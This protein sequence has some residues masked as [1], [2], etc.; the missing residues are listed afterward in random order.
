MLYH[1]TFYLSRLY[2]LVYIYIFFGKQVSSA[3]RAI[4]SPEFSMFLI[5]QYLDP[6]PFHH[7]YILFIPL[8]FF[9][10]TYYTSSLP[11]VSCSKVYTYSTHRNIRELLV[12]FDWIHIQTNRKAN[13]V[14]YIEREL[15][16]PFLLH[17]PLSQFYLSFF[18]LFP[19][20]YSSSISFNFQSTRLRSCLQNSTSVRSI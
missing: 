4:E 9:I 6:S 13:L 15:F 20:L 5:Q 18:T 17:L 3:A 8:F 7:P 1:G 10:C 2:K 16:F 12:F 14:R 11:R 19:P